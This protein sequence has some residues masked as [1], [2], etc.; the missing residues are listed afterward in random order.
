[1]PPNNQGLVVGGEVALWTEAIGPA[2]I[3]SRAWMQAAAAAERYW[4]PRSTRDIVSAQ[5]RLRKVQL[6][7]VRFMSGE[8]S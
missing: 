7:L 3:E 8:T 6:A 5:R 4:A 2:N 1:M